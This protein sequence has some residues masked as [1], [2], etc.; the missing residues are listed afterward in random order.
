MD[1]TRTR[2]ARAGRPR[3]ELPESLAWLYDAPADEQPPAAEPEPAAA[4]PP[5]PPRSAAPAPPASD[6]EALPTLLPFSAADDD[7]EGFDDEP[8][9][10]PLTAAPN[11]YLA[12]PAMPLT[13]P[14]PAWREG[15]SPWA[16]PAEPATPPPLPQA[17]PDPEPEPYELPPLFDTPRFTRPSPPPLPAD[18]W[19]STAAAED[20]FAADEPAQDDEPD[21][22]EPDDVRTVADAHEDVAEGSDL[23]GPATPA[24]PL[25]WRD[26][27]SAAAD[28]PDWMTSARPFAPFGAPSP[29]DDGVSLFEPVVRPAPLDAH[30]PGP[31][32]PAPAPVTDDREARAVAAFA[33]FA[34]VEAE[35]PESELALAPEPVPA[36]EDDVPAQA[37]DE[38]AEA[39]DELVDEAA[40][41]PVE[42]P[43]ET[44][45]EMPVK[46]P[47]KMP[48][49]AQ[50]RALDGSTVDPL[51]LIAVPAEPVVPPRPELGDPALGPLWTAVR[52]ALQSSARHTEPTV[53][54]RGL[55][56]AGRRAVAGLLGVPAVRAATRV[57][58]AELEA[59][60]TEHGGMTLAAAAERFV[61]VGQ[62][63]RARTQTRTAA[64][65]A[66]QEWLE[67][68]PAMAAQP[69]TTTWLETVRR[70][71]VGVDAGLTGHEV[72]SALAVLEAL[73]ALADDA[74]DRPAW[75]ARTE[76]AG[77]VA[78]DEHALDEGSAVAGLVLRGLAAAAGSS[79]PSDRTGR[80]RLWARFGVLPDLVSSSTLAVGVAP[81]DDT[82][83][84]RWRLAALDGVP[85]HVTGRDLRRTGAWVP[86]DEA[87]PAVLVV[88]N[89]RVLDAIADRF[90]GRVPAVC[91]D[92]ADDALALDLLGR[93]FESGTAVRFVVDFDQPGLALGSLLA[94]RFG[95]TP[96]RMA[97]DDYRASVRSDL[98]QLAGRAPEP[99]WAPGLGA[100]MTQAGRAVPVEQVLD[101][102]MAALE[103]EVG[104]G[105][106]PETS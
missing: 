31:D 20:R 35:Q 34:D 42:M 68:H 24:E 106:V 45:V 105:G 99:E 84:R 23:P 66:G 73:T 13:Q 11:A 18:L 63:R 101:E 9:P 14:R 41:E 48:V 65:R 52:E 12:P 7:V 90:G 67:A 91:A 97:A 26:L 87:W 55:D 21:G 72:T 28:T 76:L 98:P 10:F 94:R 25:P 95:A 85:V 47:V 93:L 15:P 30:Q 69:W 83:G 40:D 5:A 2:D 61:P 59:V 74:R 6:P 82:L 1:D 92:G 32:V 103:A 77:A 19:P 36:A 80:R 29:A 43:V 49:E 71:T 3:P 33:A 100:A 57:D 4:A 38:P 58:L 56:Q 64:L 44:P 37:V 39:F 50:V 16:A 17:S 79:L 22:P 81:A 54:V 89:A 78:D 70:D 104:R 88:D 86:V 8:G 60:V 102:L 46:M 51:D 75:R 53:D 27:R 96:W 62:G